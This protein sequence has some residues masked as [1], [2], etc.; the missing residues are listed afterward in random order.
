MSEVYKIQRYTYE[1]FC[2]ET[3]DARAELIRG[4]IYDMAPPS[5]KHQKLVG[6]IFFRLRYFIKENNGG[7]EVFPAPFGVRLAED[8]YVEPDISVICD[9]DKLSARGCEGAP[10]L[11]IEIASSNRIHDYVRKTS[12][13]YDAGVREYWIVD[14]IS[15]KVTVYLFEN[16]FSM[17][18]YDFTDDVPVGIY[19]GEL[20]INVS[21]L[22]SE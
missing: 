11:V 10:D 19:G 20:S 8:S 18:P 22:L 4:I 12:L 6:E 1:E 5:T 7:C 9:K 16:E 21:E 13:Y 15:E 2:E 14:P 3:K 17:M